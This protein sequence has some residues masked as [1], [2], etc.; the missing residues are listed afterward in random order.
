[1]GRMS[2]AVDITGMRFGKL[3]ALRPLPVRVDR[4]IVWLCRCDC[5]NESKATAAH[6]RSEHTKSCGCLHLQ[7]LASCKKHGRRRL[8]NGR[9]DPT[10]QTWSSMRGRCLNPNAQQFED[11][12]GRGITVCER[13]NSF[14]NFLEDMGEK[15]AGL[16]IERIDNNK[17]YS[18]D[19]C[20]WATY[21][22]QAQNRRPK[23][24]R[25]A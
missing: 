25:T 11:Y 14:E 7:F 15:P 22:E 4:K 8:P 12:G 20:K 16:T 18:P 17:G 21:H 1:M 13:W 23:K 9:Q 5:G 10:W 6:L 3:I 24:P 2:A 19:N